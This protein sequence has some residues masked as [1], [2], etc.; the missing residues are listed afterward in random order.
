MDFLTET[1]PTAASNEEFQ[2]WTDSLHAVAGKVMSIYPFISVCLMYYF[3]NNYYKRMLILKYSNN[4][5]NNNS[6]L[7]VNL[8]NRN[9]DKTHNLKSKNIS[10]VWNFPS[11]FNIAR[12]I[13]LY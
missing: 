3:H 11:Y 5:N 4:N 1:F 12:L 2:H 9:S 13:V 6:A 8:I 7:A 10:A